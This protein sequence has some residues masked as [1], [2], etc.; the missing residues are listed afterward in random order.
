[1][2]ESRTARFELV[3]TVFMALAAVG[4]AWAGFQSAKWSGVQANAYA[5]AGAAR[6]DASRQATLSGQQRSVDV[7]S[8]T[9]WLNALNDEIIAD[10]SVRPNGSYRPNPRAV[11][12]F[13]FDRFRPEFKPA[14]D[15]WLDTHPLV[16]PAAP[17]TPFD[18]PQ[19]RLAADGRAQALVDRAE[20]LSARARTAN[21]RSDN[22]VLM[23]VVFALVLLFAGLAS[24]T[25]TRQTRM[26]F[27]VLAAVA[28]AGCVV[29]LATFPVEI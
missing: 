18:M 22:Y 15:A 2:G 29:T 17:A 14:V 23:A 25:N 13:L 8:F 10:P 28:L 12:G 6:A 24:K 3:L 1:M 16:N 27:S 4:T 26:I 11:S 21:Q 20:T 7:V 5:A 9:A 19:Y